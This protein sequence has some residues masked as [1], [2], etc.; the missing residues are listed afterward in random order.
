ME[1]GG[2]LLLRTNDY[3]TEYNLG[4]DSRDKTGISKDQYNANR[5]KNGEWV[6][7]R[8]V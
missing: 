6:G 7:R 2:Q 3:W 1:Y 4:R 8:N 5:V